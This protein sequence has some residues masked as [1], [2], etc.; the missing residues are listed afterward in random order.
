MTKQMA[1]CGLA[2]G[3]AEWGV[4]GAT[5]AFNTTNMWQDGF[6]MGDAILAAVLD[7]GGGADWASRAEAK[8][9]CGEAV[10]AA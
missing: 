10:S 6:P 7:E 9:G 5:S 4:G 3:G 1:G 8:A 2:T